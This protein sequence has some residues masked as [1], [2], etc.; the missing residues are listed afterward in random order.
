[1]RTFSRKSASDD[2]A[3]STAGM[4]IFFISA[5]RPKQEREGMRGET[6]AVISI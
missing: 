5:A 4:V 1:M 2:R 6:V 3:G